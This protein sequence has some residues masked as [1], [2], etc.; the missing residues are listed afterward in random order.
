MSTLRKTGRALQTGLFGTA[1]ALVAGSASA[2]EFYSCSMRGGR[3]AAVLVVSIDPVTGSRTCLRHS[4]IPTAAPVDATS[5]CHD[6]SRRVD[7]LLL[8]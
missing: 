5:S 3:E 8:N 2:D 7:C 4:L 1:L 6:V